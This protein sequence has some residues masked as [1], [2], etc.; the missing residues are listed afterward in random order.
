M[1]LVVCFVLCGSGCWFVGLRMGLQI[2]GYFDFA[3]F[4]ARVLCFRS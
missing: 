4:R 1:L 2:V 3:I